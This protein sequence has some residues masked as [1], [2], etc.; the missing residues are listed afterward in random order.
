EYILQPPFRSYPA[1]LKEEPKGGPL[2]DRRGRNIRPPQWD[3][4]TPPFTHP[5]TARR[6]VSLI[7][8]DL[9]LIEV[10]PEGLFLRKRAPD[11][12]VDE[13]IERTE[14]TLKVEGDVKTMDAK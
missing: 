8:T 4:F 9:A 2:L 10:A 14:V 3:S 6:V 13:I 7:I 11:V 12:T 5:L 1:N